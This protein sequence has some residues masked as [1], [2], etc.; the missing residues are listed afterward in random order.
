MNKENSVVQSME[1]DKV[2][3]L[4]NARKMGGRNALNLSL[5]VTR[6]SSGGVTT[7]V[8]FTVHYLDYLLVDYGLSG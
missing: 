5:C 6:I 2:N 8:L 1:S 7:F 4:S 3:A